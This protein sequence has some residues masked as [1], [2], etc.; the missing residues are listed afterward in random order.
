MVTGN[1][2]AIRELVEDGVTGLTI[3]SGDSQALEK[4]LAELLADRER[5]ETLGRA[6]RRRVEEEF[7][8]TLNARRLLACFAR[9]G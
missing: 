9:E 6:G 1:L 5:I 4:V 7:D 8:L 3:P 2:E